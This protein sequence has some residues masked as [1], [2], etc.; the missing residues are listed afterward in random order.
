[1]LVLALHDLGRL[2]RVADVTAAISTE[3]LMG[4]DRAFAADLVAMRPQPGQ[5]RSA[6]NMRPAAGRLADRGQPP[7]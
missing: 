3:A 7:P 2:L 5:A 4:T 1:M 6:A